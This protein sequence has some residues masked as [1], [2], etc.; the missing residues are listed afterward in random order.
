MQSSGIFGAG[1]F[2]QDAVSLWEDLGACTIQHMQESY[3]SDKS[4]KSVR[5]KGC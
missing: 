5:N 3:K 1:S 4:R 2:K